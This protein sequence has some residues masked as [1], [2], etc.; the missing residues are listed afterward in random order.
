M[1]FT[2]NHRKTPAL[3]TSLLIATGK[4]LRLPDLYLQPQEDSLAAHMK[5]PATCREFAVSL[6]SPAARCT[7]CRLPFPG[8]ACPKHTCTHIAFLA[9]AF[10]PQALRPFHGRFLQAMHL[11]KPTV[12]SPFPVP[13]SALM[14]LPL[15]YVHTLHGTLLPNPAVVLLAG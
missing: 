14:P 11:V 15:Q 12:F 6:N 4:H 3:A 13:L 9:D 7:S 5:A 8:E 2:Y 1:H 10:G